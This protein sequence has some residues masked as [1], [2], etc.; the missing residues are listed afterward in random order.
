[1]SQSFSLKLYLE[2]RR[3]DV[4]AKSPASGFCRNVNGGRLVCAPAAVEPRSEKLSGCA[5]YLL[6]TSALNGEALRRPSP[7]AN[8]MIFSSVHVFSSWQTLTSVKKGL[9]Q[10]DGGWLEIHHF[11]PCF[12]NYIQYNHLLKT[13]SWTHLQCL[14]PVA[15][16]QTEEK[17]P[18][19]TDGPS[20][21]GV[22]MLEVWPCDV[23]SF[24]ALEQD[25]NDGSVQLYLKV[26]L[27]FGTKFYCIQSDNGFSSILGC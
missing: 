17:N 14:W 15:Q 20:P 19:L 9:V 21:F 13:A 5:Q 24:P 7:P 22:Y 4:P 23:T 8:I 10:R 26:Q 2:D 11:L 25:P 12:V 6:M 18:S 3:V 1:M 27:H 16:L